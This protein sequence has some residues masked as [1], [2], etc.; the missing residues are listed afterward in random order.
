LNQTSHIWQEEKIVIVLGKL[1]DKEGVPK[2]L[3][4]GVCEVT[5]TNVK[6]IAA[7]LKKENY[8]PNYSK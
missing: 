7:R 1:S 6:E 8:H 3:C 5:P 2:L 4:Q